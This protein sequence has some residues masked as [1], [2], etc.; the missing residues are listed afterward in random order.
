M[1]YLNTK[2]FGFIL[3]LAVY[4]LLHPW[5]IPIIDVRNTSCGGLVIKCSFSLSHGT[6]DM[7]CILPFSSSSSQG[8][9]V[10]LLFLLYLETVLVI[11]SVFLHRV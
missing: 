8:F 11:M 9:D 6:N 4:L 7:F 2:S 5:Q 3:C 1:R 10:L